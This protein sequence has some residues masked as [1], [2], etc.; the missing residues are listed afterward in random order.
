MVYRSF[1]NRSLRRMQQSF[2][3]KE[4]EREAMELESKVQFL[5]SIAH[6]DRTPLSLN[7]APVEKLKASMAGM[8]DQDRGYLDV[9]DRNCSRLGRLITQL[10]DFSRFNQETS[11][12]FDFQKGDVALIVRSVCSSFVP[13]FDKDGIEFT[14]E[15]PEEP[16]IADVDMESLTT[17]VMNLLSN[18]VKYTNDKVGLKCSCDDDFFTVA[19]SDNGPGIS[20][21]LRGRIFHPYFR[22]DETSVGTGLGLAIL[23][24]L[25]DALGGNVRVSDAQGGGSIFAVSLPVHQPETSLADSVED[26]E[27]STAADGEIKDEM[28]QHLKTGKADRQ[29]ILIVEDDQSAGNALHRSGIPPR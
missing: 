14:E 28:P 24:K 17:I 2:E 5:T 22:A 4:S 10:L 20:E 1:R 13:T 11:Q 6:G 7:M 29:T 15:Y 12:S 9:I 27:T 23:K 3:K 8:S 19:V 16:I 26:S 25:V 21:E 18:A